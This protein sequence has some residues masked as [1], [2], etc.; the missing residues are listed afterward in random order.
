MSC[1][2]LCNAAV[3]A[4]SLDQVK[5]DYALTGHDAAV[6]EAVWRGRGLPVKADRIFDAMYADDPDGGP[7]PTRMYRE[8]R[9]A[10]SRLGGKLSGSR[11]A[12]EPVGYRR[13]FRLTLR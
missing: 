3:G 9:A 13:G 2:P 5:A 11:I 10:L 1:C 4:P 12:V 6:L 7:M 8:L